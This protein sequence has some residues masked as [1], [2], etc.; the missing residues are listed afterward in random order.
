[1][2]RV[3]Q[4]VKI[5]GLIITLHPYPRSADYKIIFLNYA[6]HMVGTV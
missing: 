3:P 4:K 2:P 6:R 1:M 5:L